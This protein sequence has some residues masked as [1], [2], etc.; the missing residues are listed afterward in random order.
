LAACV[1]G[2]NIRWC[3]NNEELS[4]VE[5]MSHAGEWDTHAE[6]Q[7]RRWE[8]LAE[9]KAATNELAALY[10]SRMFRIATVMVSVLTVLVGSKGLSTIIVGGASAVEIAIGVCEI[11]LGVSA[12]LLSNMELKNKAASFSKRSAGYNKIAS[13]LRVQM[14]LRPDER[15]PK[16]ELLASIPTQVQE[17]EDTA[18]PL[19]LRYREEAERMR[20]RIP[21]L[22]N[23]G[24][25]AAVLT[26]GAGG[27]AATAHPPHY[28][29]D[30]ASETEG[31][32][33]SIL[34]VIISQR[35]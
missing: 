22:W 7:A 17:M 27:P 33:S 28:T 21:G 5:D 29:Y 9:M 10:Y 19:P 35:M 1:V 2:Y 31:N 24:S 34:D 3:I 26:A 6:N 18:E 32:S 16:R 30:V 13:V 25:S 8:K 12:T 23:Q 4:G 11:L 15:M 20:G 14:V